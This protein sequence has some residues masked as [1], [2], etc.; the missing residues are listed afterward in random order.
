M[1]KTEK[2]PAALKRAWIFMKNFFELI[3]AGTGENKIP[4][5]C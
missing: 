5:Y 1:K 2:K 4:Q 3:T